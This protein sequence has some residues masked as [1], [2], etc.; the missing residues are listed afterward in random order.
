MEISDN[1][2]NTSIFFDTNE[3]GFKQNTPAYLI[4]IQPSFY[5]NQYNL[6]VNSDGVIVN[7]LYISSITNASNNGKHLTISNNGKIQVGN[8]G[9]GLEIDS[10]GNL[11]AK[12]LG[13]ITVGNGLNL[14]LTTGI[15]QA[16][17]LGAASV[18]DG[19]EIVNG[20][21]KAKSLGTATV[22][23][24][25]HLDSTTNVIDINQSVLD[26]IQNVLDTLNLKAPINNPTFTGTVGGIDKTMVG[27]E[28]VDNTS[29]ADKPVSTATATEL[30]LKAPLADPTFTGTVSGIDKTMVGLENVDNTSDADKPVSTATTTELALKAP[31]ADPTFTGTVSGIDKTM[32]GLE[33]VDNTSDADKPVSTATTTELALKAPLADPTFTG[34]VG[35]IDKTMVGLENVD[36]T[37]DADKPVSSAAANALALKAPLAD[38]TFTG[39]VSGIDKTMVGLENIDNTSDANKPV[40][41]ATANALA[42]KAPLADP[43]FT[44]TVSGI[45]KTMVGL[46]NIDNTSDADKPVSTATQNALNTKQN[47]IVDGDLTIANTT[48]LQTELDSKVGLSG[49]E[50]VNGSKTFSSDIV[51]DITGNAATSTTTT[52]LRVNGNDLNLPSNTGSEGQ[53]LKLN[54]TGNLEWAVNEDAI[55]KNNDIEVKNLN[56]YGTAD[57][58]GSL[59]VLDEVLLEKDVKCKKDITIEGS[60][61]TNAFNIN[62]VVVT[63]T[64]DKLVF[65]KALAN[66]INVDNLNVAYNTDIS[67]LTVD[68]INFGNTRDHCKPSGTII[69]ESGVTIKFI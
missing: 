6:K 9:N 59:H 35:G 10:G 33:N 12:P 36:N 27:L 23:A 41:S 21:L 32:V 56:V 47:N 17:E 3:L 20:V 58:S 40:S 51:G 15:L 50:T 24:N 60:I 7:D 4:K 48:G 1:N 38:P 66:N 18:G 22:G 68:Y 19:L 57:V 39:T 63:N 62:G 2:F 49:D 26:N 14:D 45:D 64:A 11:N 8:L 25:L 43:T 29:D 69:T 13:G 61:N 34:T 44:G 37:S 65:D 31:L 53:V 30:A 16:D 67:N 52:K 28:N 5:D 42:L 54:D 55:D 46:E